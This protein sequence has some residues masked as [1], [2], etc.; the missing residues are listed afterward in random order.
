M[1]R[2][3]PP[4]WVLFL[5]IFFLRRI[6]ILLRH[7]VGAL[8]YERLGAG[9]SCPPFHNTVTPR[10]VLVFERG[11]VGIGLS[12]QEKSLRAGLPCESFL[13]IA[14]SRFKVRKP[15]FT[16]IFLNFWWAASGLLVLGEGLSRET[17]AI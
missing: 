11:V 3:R 6:H 13:L 7:P 1:P 10:Q 8:C 17:F 4:Q 2:V 9:G 14:F 15:F 12:Q 5:D 16:A